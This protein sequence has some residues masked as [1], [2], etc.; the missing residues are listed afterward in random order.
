[1]TNDD[2]GP[3]SARY[4]DALRALLRYA[5]VMA[6]VGLLVGV[7]YQESAKKLSLATTGAGLHLE[8]VIGLALVHGHIFTIGVL[9]PLALAGALLMARRAGGRE[10][11]QRSLHWLVRGYLPAAAVTLV[12]QLVKGYHVLLAVRGGQTDLAAIDH[13]FL[14]GQE[15]LRYALFG[16]SHTAMGVCLVVFLVALW[17]SLRRG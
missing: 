17:R 6:I 14:G 9:L 4:R 1:M 16:V 8:A 3:L 2:S 15:V 12:L 7:A 11:G 10:I 5:I 13:A